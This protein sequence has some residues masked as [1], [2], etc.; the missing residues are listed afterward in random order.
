MKRSFGG[1]KTQKME[2]TGWWAS[3]TT[4]IMFEDVHVPVEYVLGEPGNGFRQMM[5][6]LNHERWFVA[7]EKEKTLSLFCAGFS[8][9]PK[10]RH[11]PTQALDRHQEY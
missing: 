3:G 11:L 9:D 4:Y 5:T 10:N 2:V 8:D 1:V 6:N 7:G